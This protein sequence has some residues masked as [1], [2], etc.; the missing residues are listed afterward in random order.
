MLKYPEIVHAARHHAIAFNK[1]VVVYQKGKKF[2]FT[3]YGNFEEQVK[4]EPLIKL[5]ICLPNGDART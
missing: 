3:P 2:Y 1:M 5:I 4:V